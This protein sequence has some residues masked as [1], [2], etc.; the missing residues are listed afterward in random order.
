MIIPDKRLRLV[1]KPVTRVDADIRTLVEDMFETMYE[2]PGI[3]LAAIQIGVAKRVVVMDLSKKEERRRRKSSSTRKSLVLGGK[4]DL[5]GGL[6]V[7]PGDHEDVDRPQRV[8]VRFLDLDGKAHETKLTACSRPAS[9]TRS[10]TSTACCS[11][12]TFPAQARPHHQ[13]IHQGGQGGEDGE[14]REACLPLRLVF[15]GTPDFAVPSLLELVGGGHDIAAVYTRAAQPA[16]RGM[17]LRESPVE[18]EARKLGHRCA[19]R[20][21]CER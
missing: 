19:R 8:K 12:I 20:R 9:S 14:G 10:T 5:R 21:R 18:R 3:G 2:A 17:E 15:M 16:G 1:S 11:S 13:E 7:D 6:P 4:I